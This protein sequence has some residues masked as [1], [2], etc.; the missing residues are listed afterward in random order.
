MSTESEAAAETTPD[1]TTPEP[2]PATE[3]DTPTDEH[4]AMPDARWDADK[5]AY[6]STAPPEPRSLPWWKAKAHEHE[7]TGKW[8]VAELEADR[9]EL[10]SRVESL[11]KQQVENLIGPRL[12]NPADFFHHAELAEVLD[13]TG[14]VD[15]EKLDTVLADI[16]QSAPYLAP[17]PAAPSSA[18]TSEHAGVDE[19]NNKPSFGDLLKAAA[20]S[21]RGIASE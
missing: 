2:E 11:Q 15:T 14:T 16:I 7:N 17:S 3:P 9:A 10:R 19:K 4:P 20:S 8:L 1:T 6:T 21:N 18:V 12:H 13:D 5:G